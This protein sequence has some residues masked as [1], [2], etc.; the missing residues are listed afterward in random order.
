MTPPVTTT[1]SFRFA[2]TLLSL[3]TAPVV[4]VASIPFWR[5]EVIRENPHDSSGFGIFG[6]IFGVLITAAASAIVGVVFALLAHRRHERLWGVRV[7]T[8]LA[9]TCIIAFVVYS[10]ITW[11]G[12]LHWAK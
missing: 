3:F 7:F 11:P 8:L 5:V 2:F 6:I 10:L 1:R 4:A 12:G 9:N